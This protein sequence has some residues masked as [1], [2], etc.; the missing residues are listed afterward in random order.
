MYGFGYDEVGDDYKVVV[1]L[2]NK[3]Q[4]VYGLFRVTVELYSP[5]NDSWMSI[6]YFESRFLVIDSGMFVNGKLHWAN[7]IADSWDIVSIDLADRKW[8]KFGGALL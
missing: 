6:E 5:N 3:K 7:C 1:G 8:G 2:R 4:S